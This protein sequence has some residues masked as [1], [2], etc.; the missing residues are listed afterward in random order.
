MEIGQEFQTAVSLHKAGKLEAA[1]AAIAPARDAIPI[2]L[3]T[4]TDN[5][6]L[7]ILFSREN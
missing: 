5:L 3:V 7:F 2:A 1:S 6:F 4:A